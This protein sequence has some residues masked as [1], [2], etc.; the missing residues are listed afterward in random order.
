MDANKT[1]NLNDLGDFRAERFCKHRQ[2]APIR[3]HRALEG[4]RFPI[5]S[6]RLKWAVSGTD[7]VGAAVPQTVRL[8]PF[9]LVLVTAQPNELCP[10]LTKFMAPGRDE[11]P[12][13]DRFELI[14]EIPSYGALPRLADFIERG[15]GP[16]GE[17]PKCHDLLQS[18]AL[19]LIEKLQKM[20]AI[21]GVS[22][23][24]CKRET[25]ARTG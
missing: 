22:R 8:I 17:L 9:C 24:C 2:F 15:H 18:D 10:T 23:A 7:K 3:R 21:A 19:Y 13:C 6:M 11:S 1:P 5:S 14:E 4:G 25:I 12:D 20:L 16:Q